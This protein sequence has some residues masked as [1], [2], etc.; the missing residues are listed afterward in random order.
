MIFRVIFWSIVL[1]FIVRFFIRFFYPILQMTK[2]ANDRVQQMQKEMNN[3]QQRAN[4][5]ASN[6]TPKQQPRQVDG[7]YIEYEEVK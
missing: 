7:D 6:P 4:A 1:I 3:M 2:M 5:Q